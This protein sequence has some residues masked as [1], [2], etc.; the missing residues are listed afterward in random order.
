MLFFYGLIS[1][2]CWTVHQII[3]TSQHV[4][5]CCYH[6]SLNYQSLSRRWYLRNAGIEIYSI[7]QEICTRFLLC[8]ALLWLY[9]DWFSHIH[10][11]Y[12]TWGKATLMNMDKYFMWIHY[13]RLNNHNKAKHNKTVCIFLEIYCIGFFRPEKNHRMRRKTCATAQFLDFYKILHSK[14]SFN[15]LALRKI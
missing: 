7:S 2:G 13:D 10:Q 9:I 3:I 11:A 6:R 12:F 14:I 1:N 8:C 4:L 5:Q 15:N